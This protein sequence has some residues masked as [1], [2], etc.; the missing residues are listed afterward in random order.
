MLISESK[1]YVFL[2]NPKTGTTAIQDKLMNLDKSARMNR[3]YSNG[4]MKKFPEHGNGLILEEELGSKVDEYQIFTFIRDPYDKIVSSYFFY[5]NGKP[6]V[7]G[8]LFVYFKGGYRIFLK[9]FVSYLN[10]LLA[11]LLPFH[12]WSLLRRVK[13][14][15]KYLVGSNGEFWLTISVKLRICLKILIQLF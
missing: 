10:I 4:V 6:L 5:K 1:K 12:V 9:A 11:R 7:N 15:E 13:S 14:N 2:S 8:N 3:I